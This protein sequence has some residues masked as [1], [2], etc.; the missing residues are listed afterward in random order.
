MIL[1]IKIFALLSTVVLAVHA[2]TSSAA[3]S[4]ELLLLA[5]V[6]A[7]KM[8]HSTVDVPARKWQ[9]QV[10]LHLQLNIISIDLKCVSAQIHSTSRWPRNA[11]H[12]NV[13]QLRKPPPLPSKGPSVPAVSIHEHFYPL[14]PLTVIFVG[15]VSDSIY[16]FV[17]AVPSSVS[18]VSGFPLD[19]S[20]KASSAPEASPHSF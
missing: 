10:Y 14:L 12:L 13:P 20:S 6:G 18:Y 3:S 11:S 17:R 7:F 16:E 19:H 2:Q 1:A 9:L 4:R 15:T 8:V 5:L